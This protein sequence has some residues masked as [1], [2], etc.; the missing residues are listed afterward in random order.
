[1]FRSSSVAGAII[2]AT[3]RWKLSTTQTLGLRLTLIA[4]HSSLHYILPVLHCTP[5]GDAFGFHFYLRVHRKLVCSCHYWWTVALQ[6]VPD[7][8]RILTAASCS[9]LTVMWQYFEKFGWVTSVNLTPMT[10]NQKQRTRPSIGAIWHYLRTLKF[11]KKFKNFS[12]I[13]S[14]R[15]NMCD[16]SRRYAYVHSK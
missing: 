2:F 16:Q 5:Q 15:S 13:L 6:R 12:G 7:S 14:G 9:N 4:L 8:L 3:L 1:M 10:V 11:S